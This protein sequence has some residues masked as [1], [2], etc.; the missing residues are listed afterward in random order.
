MR[1]WCYRK[2][3]HKQIGFIYRKRD[4]TKRLFKT[5][6]LKPTAEPLSASTADLL[7]NPGGPRCPRLSIF[8]P[9]CRPFGAG[10]LS[11]GEEGCFMLHVQ[12]AAPCPINPESVR[13][14]FCQT[15]L[16]WM[17]GAFGLMNRA[18]RGREQGKSPPSSWERFRR[19]GVGHSGSGPHFHRPALDLASV[20]ERLGRH[21]V[22]VTF[23][24]HY[25]RISARGI[26]STKH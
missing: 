23:D 10:K 3:P 25:I 20:N 21:D 24:N 11:G 12:V 18:E 19:R 14:G 2:L 7:K 17:A 4:K 5:N 15:C 9:D 22:M 16:C 26:T 13:W 8:H 1:P 6:K